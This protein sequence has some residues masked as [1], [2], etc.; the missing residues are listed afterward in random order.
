[1]ISTI[2]GTGDGSSSITPNEQQQPS[3]RAQN[4]YTA[5]SGLNARRRTMLRRGDWRKR[6]TIR[7]RNLAL[8][9][10]CCCALMQNVIV[11]GANNAI[12]ST[13]EKAYYMT[14]VESAMFLSMYDI[15]N[16]I[17]SPIIG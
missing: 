4:Q 12:L 13:I 6:L 17:A 3:A 11:G 16:I 10:L 15:A 2:S 14:S 8:G 7:N 5:N 9:I 1:M